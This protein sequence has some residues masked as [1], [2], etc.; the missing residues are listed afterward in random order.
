[1]K[2]MTRLAVGMLLD[3]DQ[4]G[5]TRLANRLSDALHN[6]YACP[7][8]GHAGPHDDNGRSGEDRELCC[9]GCGEVFAPVED[10][11]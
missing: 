7:E 2:N 1:M 3:D 8:C 4:A 10:M 6:R 9:A 11:A 5:L